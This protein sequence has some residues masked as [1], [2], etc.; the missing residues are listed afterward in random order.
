MRLSFPLEKFK[1]QTH[2]SPLV[3]DKTQGMFEIHVSELDLSQ[4]AVDRIDRDFYFTSCTLTI[5]WT[6]FDFEKTVIR[7]LNPVINENSVKTSFFYTIDV[8]DE[9]MERISENNLIL[10]LWAS[11]GEK[12]VYLGSGELNLFDS[13][14]ILQ[15]DLYATVAFS[16]ADKAALLNNSTIVDVYGTLSL[17]YRF[18]CDLSTLNDGS[19][20]GWQQKRR[21]ASI[22]GFHLPSIDS[23]MG[24]SSSFDPAVD[25]TDN[26]IDNFQE[27]LDSVLVRNRALKLTQSEISNELED[28]ARWLH[29]ESNWKRT[30]Q[31]HAILTGKDPNAVQWRQW[32]SSSSANVQLRDYE[33]E[34]DG[35]DLKVIILITR[36]KLFDVGGV[37]E[38]F[39][40]RYSFLTH[41]VKSVNQSIS[42]R[43]VLFKFEK[44]FPIHPKDN[45]EDCQKL[46]K[47]IKSKEYFLISLIG[48]D[49][50]LKSLEIGTAKISF[51]ELIKMTTNELST[52]LP[53]RDRETDV[54]YV[55]VSIT[56]I[57][58]M[59]E[60]AL[61]LMAPPDFLIT[62]R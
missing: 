61:K 9:F 52:E 26:E 54:G 18:S 10:Q 37:F 62:D 7:I 8:C 2:F 30:L 6:L 14:D 39:F 29:D 25:P 46:V 36:A 3:I 55:V 53:L 15:N 13:I 32:R 4:M 19:F 22:I 1:Q 41:D 51:F 56:G 17:R 21:T 44:V 42:K 28:R 5:S 57:L 48:E 11:E 24:S 43:D 31:E 58:A 34:L 12:E 60:V 23:S 33:T 27:A 38:K 47:H 16:D 35:H 59:R 40:V 50:F 49:Q 45:E 20:I